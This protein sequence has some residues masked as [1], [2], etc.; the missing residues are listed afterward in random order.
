MLAEVDGALA[1]GIEDVLHERHGNGSGWRT[2]AAAF[3]VGAKVE[4]PHLAPLQ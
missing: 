3:E 1:L 2:V 4:H